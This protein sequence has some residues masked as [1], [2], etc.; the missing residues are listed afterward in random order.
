[1]DKLAEKV[2]GRA[3]ERLGER[4][5]YYT[6]PNHVPSEEIL[7]HNRKNKIAEDPRKFLQAL[8]KGDSLIF[9]LK[10]CNDNRINVRLTYN[11]HDPEYSERGSCLLDYV[12]PVDALLT[13]I[14]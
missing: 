6:F 14:F 9:H 13:R 3:P 1:M 5:T 10:T 12:R 11:V 4:G 7:H 8:W 2:E